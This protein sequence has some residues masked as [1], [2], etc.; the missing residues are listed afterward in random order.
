[1][2]RKD[3]NH[4]MVFVPTLM[5]L[6]GEVKKPTPKWVEVLQVVGVIAF[7]LSLMV[8]LGMGI[9]AALAYHG[10]PFP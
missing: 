10:I 4:V 5:P 7:G 9:I 1:M 3:G 8:S 2:Q 6:P